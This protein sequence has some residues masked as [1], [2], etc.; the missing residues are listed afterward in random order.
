M[1]SKSLDLLL[2][3][4]CSGDAAAAEQVFLAYEP[5]LRKVVRRQLP[6]RLRAKLDSVD[7]VQSIWAD[8]LQGFRSAGWRFA[9][10]AHLRAF[11]VKATQHR[12]I[13]RIRQHERAVKLEKSLAC[14]DPEQLPPAKQPRPSEAVQA[15]DLWQRML[16]LCPPAHHQILELKRQGLTLVEIAQRT[17]LHEGSVRRILRQLARQMALKQTPLPGPN[18]DG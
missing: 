4:L 17:G 10:A 7:V 6:P 9:D 13:D 1:S 5:Y 15:D 3:K 11:L 14:T 18:G 8:V 2:E 16:T 12:F